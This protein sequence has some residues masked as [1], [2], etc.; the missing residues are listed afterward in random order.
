[1][2]SRALVTNE[3]RLTLID[4]LA[5]RG[6]E[7][8]GRLPPLPQMSRELGISVA[9]LREQLEVAKALG[10]VE[11]RP[12]TGIRRLPYTFA[13]AVKKSLSYAVAV[14]ADCFKHYS[15]LR[16]RLEAA[17]WYE[18]VSLLTRDDHV[19]LRELL[20]S[21][22]DKLNGSPI[23]VPHLEHRQLHLKIFSRLGNLFVT[24]LLEAYWD[25]Y[26]QSGLD[27]YTDI[28]YLQR[29]WKYHEK[30]VDSIC[31]GE[32]ASGYVALTEHM[33]LLF[34]RVKPLPQ[35]LFE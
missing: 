32:F 6:L 1:M 27:V 14:D 10:L 5:W 2:I 31:S 18:A 4:Y 30:M 17:Y 26:E 23:Q 3:K 28:D 20:Q 9:S 13:P 19:N 35:Q 25:I 29:V 34:Q 11:V 15:G 22:L 12:R 16:N 33:D 21:A 24:G 8:S 7:G